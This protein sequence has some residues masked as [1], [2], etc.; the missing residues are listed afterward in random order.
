MIQPSQLTWQGIWFLPQAY[1]SSMWQV[2]HQLLWN[3][4][5]LAEHKNPNYN[6]L[7]NNRVNE[8]AGWLSHAWMGT[9]QKPAVE[10]YWTRNTLK[11][12]YTL[13]DRWVF[14]S[15]FECSDRVHQVFIWGCVCNNYRMVEALWSFSRTVS[16][17]TNK[18]T[19]GSLSTS[20]MPRAQSSLQSHLLISDM[21]L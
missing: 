15:R 6:Y 13:V 20:N 4:M 9:K 8:C 18:Q 5:F 16:H 1:K 12:P 10:C 2:V 7:L 11:G 17:Y 14:P 3:T 21:H 19:L